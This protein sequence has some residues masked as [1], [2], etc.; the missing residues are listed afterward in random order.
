MF[1]PSGDGSFGP[2]TPGS[3]GHLGLFMFAPVGAGGFPKDRTDAPKTLL[4]H[5]ARKVGDSSQERIA[6][7]AILCGPVQPLDSSNDCEIG[8]VSSTWGLGEMR[9]DRFQIADKGRNASEWRRI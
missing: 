5:Q 8:R 1:A 6:A 7:F 3:F 4:S 2:P 9:P